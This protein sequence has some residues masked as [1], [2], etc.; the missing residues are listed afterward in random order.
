[1]DDLRRE[2]D[3]AGSPELEGGGHEA[4]HLF[5]RDGSPIV[6]LGHNSETCLCKSCL[7]VPSP[8]TMA[9]CAGDPRRAQDSGSGNRETSPDPWTTDHEPTEP[10][11][12]HGP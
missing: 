2:A 10:A 4:Q 11:G 12:S 8:G 3:P 5:D 6:P 7:L 9:G 1:M